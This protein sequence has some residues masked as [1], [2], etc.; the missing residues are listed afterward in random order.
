M[1]LRFA[2]VARALDVA[3]RRHGLRMPSFRSPPRIAGATRTL[4]RRA[5]G[6][7]MVSVVIRGRPWP[8]VLADMVDGVLATNDLDGPRAEPLRRALWDAVGRAD[9]QAA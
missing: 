9:E 5:D 4:R 7:T 8:A 6:G 2:A 1:S 3:A